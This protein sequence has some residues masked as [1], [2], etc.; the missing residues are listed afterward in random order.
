MRRAI[1]W[2]M[3]DAALVGL[4]IGAVVGTTI[5]GGIVGLAQRVSP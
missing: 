5:V 3:L 4:A 2:L 1:G